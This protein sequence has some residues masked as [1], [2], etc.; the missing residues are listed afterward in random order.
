MVG[1][2]SNFFKW[3]VQLENHISFIASISYNVFTITAGLP[4]ER[5]ISFVL[6]EPD[7][8]SEGSS[9]TTVTLQV[10]KRIAI[11]LFYF[12]TCLVKNQTWKNKVV[13]DQKLWLPLCTPTLPQIR[14]RPPPPPSNCLSKSLYWQEAPPNS[15]RNW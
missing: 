11:K 10:V 13:F 9:N 5:K 4:S 1:Q 7:N 6:H 2:G 8:G 3:L 14:L 15:S 12:A